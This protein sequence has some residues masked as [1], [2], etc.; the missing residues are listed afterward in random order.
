MELNYKYFYFCSIYNYLLSENMSEIERDPLNMEENSTAKF[1]EKQIII[2]GSPFIL[3][4]S[5]IGNLLV[6]IIMS[7]LCNLVWSTCVYIAVFAILDLSIVYTWCGNQWL[8]HVVDIDVSEK[9]ITYSESV[10][11][12]YNF[13]VNCIYQMGKWLS[14][15]MAIECFI[16]AKYPK[17]TTEMC[18]LSRAKAIILLLTVIIFLLELAGK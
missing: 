10:C 5:T 6:C 18:T 15:C 3:L 13:I 12:L 4:L 9:F 11:K 2:Y 1:V 8:F 14:V 7:R 16:A 17:R